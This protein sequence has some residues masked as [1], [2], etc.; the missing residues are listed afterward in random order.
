VEV[1]TTRD[2]AVLTVTL[3]RPQVL[4]ALNDAMH[5]GLAAALSSAAKPDVRAVVITGEGRGFCVGADVAELPSDPQ[6]IAQLLRRRFNPN[7]RAIRGLEKPVIAAVN[8]PAAGAGLA[9][10]MACD[11]RVAAES[12]SFV[13]AFAGIGLVPDSGLSYTLPR[14]IGPAAAFDWLV[15]NRKMAAAEAAD[16]GLVSRVVADGD[17]RPATA[18]LASGL[19]AGPTVAVGLT[20]ALIARAGE[21]TLDEQ[22]ELEAQLQAVAARTAD[23]AEGVAAFREK[24]PPDFTGS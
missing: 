7:I 20:K 8:G 24:R 23:F 12:A 14:L 1:E 17:L 10:A 21:A 2:G 18:E 19:A 15:S 11:L 13:P 9:L 22:L 16:R 3:N 4:N 5:E 6:A